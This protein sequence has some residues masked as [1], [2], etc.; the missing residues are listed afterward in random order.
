VTVLERQQDYAD[1]FHHSGM[2][3]WSSPLDFPDVSRGSRSEDPYFP[4]GPVAKYLETDSNGI[5]NHVLLPW[6]WYR[7]HGGLA[8]CS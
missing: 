6:E 4:N 7:F 1:R 2:S 3:P 8:V 5:I